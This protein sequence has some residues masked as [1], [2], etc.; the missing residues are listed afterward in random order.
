[1]RKQTWFDDGVE[2]EGGLMK[3]KGLFGAIAVVEEDGQIEG[4]CCEGEAGEEA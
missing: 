2:D 3:L 4:P 1:M